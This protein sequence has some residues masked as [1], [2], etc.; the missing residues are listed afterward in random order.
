MIRTMAT[1]GG[2]HTPE[3]WAVETATHITPT[4][5]GI[6]QDR[7]LEVERLRLKIA[8]ALVVHHDRVQREER[9]HLATKGDARFDEPHD[10]SHL[11]D[12]MVADVV[13]AAKGS[14]FEAHFAKPEVQAVIRQEVH[15][16]FVTV[17][18]IERLWHGDRN[19]SSAAKAYRERFHP[20]AN[21]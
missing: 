2:P 13:D 8:E 19:P 18:H 9:G 20:A 5:P 11:L 15:G 14:P 3:K 21:S 17:Q 7:L 4:D 12:Q 10:A 6:T 1:N 16:H